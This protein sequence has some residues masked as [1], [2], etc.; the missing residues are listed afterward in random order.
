MEEK[1]SMN[2]CEYIIHRASA[3]DRNQLENLLKKL[4]VYCESNTCV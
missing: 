4:H 3:S 2:Q 1:H